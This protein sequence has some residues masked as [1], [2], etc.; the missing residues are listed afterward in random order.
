MKNT[1][2]SRSLQ[3]WKQ[4]GAERGIA[5]YIRLMLISLAVNHAVVLVSS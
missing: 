5:L 3:L 2:K 4:L 1:N